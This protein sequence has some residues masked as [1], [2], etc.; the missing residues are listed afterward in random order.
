MPKRG[1][2]LAKPEFPPFGNGSYKHPPFGNGSYEYPPFGN[3]SYEFPPFGNGSAMFDTIDPVPRLNPS[4]RYS[5]SI[6]YSF[7]SDRMNI[8]SSLIAGVALKRLSSPSKSLE[9]TFSSVSS[10]LTT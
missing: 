4:Q 2:S 9:A 3:G 8:W 1:Y 5:P 6:Q 10:A 7:V